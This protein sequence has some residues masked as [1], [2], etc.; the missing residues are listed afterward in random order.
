MHPTSLPAGFSAWQSPGLA[1]HV[2]HKLATAKLPP[3]TLYCGTLHSATAVERL[4]E[5]LRNRGITVTAVQRVTGGL[6]CLVDQP[7]IAA[8]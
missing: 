4:T 6:L 5:F 8:A 1:I 2:S 3:V 7:P